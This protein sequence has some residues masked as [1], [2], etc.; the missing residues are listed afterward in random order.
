MEKK[1]ITKV[2]LI[3]SIFYFSAVVFAGNIWDDMVKSNPSLKGSPLPT[4]LKCGFPLLLEAYRSPTPEIL[5]KIR[6]YRRDA[7]RRVGEIYTSPSGHFIIH[8][9]TSGNDAIPTYDRNQNGTPD[10]LE[11]VG[12][13]FD[14]AWRVEL[15]TLGFRIPLD[16]AG[17]SK[18]TYEVFC[19]NLRSQRLYGSTLFD[20]NEE[21]TNIPGKNYPSTIE[22]STDFSF[23]NYPGVS[24]NILRDSMAIAVTA[25]HEFNHASHL[26]YNIW[27]AI[28]DS[29]G[30]DP[31][32]LWFIESSATYME[33]VV[34]NEVNDYYQYIPSLFNSPQKGLMFYS[35]F[36]RIYGQA[37]INIMLGMVYGRTITREI[38]EEIMNRPALQAHD[39]VLLGKGSK[40]HTELQR[41]SQWM[42]FTDKNAL[43]GQFF[44]EA[45][46]YP[47]PKME[48]TSS[49]QSGTQ[50]VYADDLPPTAIQFLVSKVN[51]QSDFNIRISPQSNA[52]NWNG[53]YFVFD[54]PY[55]FQYP[56]N[57]NK[58]V[59]VSDITANN[60]TIFSSVITGIWNDGDVDSKIHYSLFLRSGSVSES[61]GITV[62]PNPLKP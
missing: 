35:P 40:L 44:P 36:D 29:S 46:V 41:L 55:R 22:I 9:E 26:S 59:P 10:Y 51:S 23:V 5:Q 17:N 53:Q 18:S 12:N 62:Y 34:A 49:Y 33:E 8:Y 58:Q 19:K 7:Q 48:T 45:A 60:D 38:W 50:E 4:T 24:D 15:D 13:S 16:A 27:N 43:A 32:D 6:K 14:R 2:L 57:V 11:F 56:A 52:G 28:P 61:P 47:L 3:S 31:L 54:S 37:A 30:F 21:I 1:L 39:V 20:L 25:A 42:F